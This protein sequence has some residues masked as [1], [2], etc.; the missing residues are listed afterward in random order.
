MYRTITRIEAL[1]SFFQK[2]SKIMSLTRKMIECI[3]RGLI[4]S[5]SSTVYCAKG[6]TL[7]ETIV[8]SA[9]LAG[10]A[11]GATYFF[12]QN[13]TIMLS[14]SQTMGCQAIAKQ[15]LESVMS[16][17]S[18]LYGYKVN[19]SDP[20][21][22][23]R[24]VWLQNNDIVL[25]QFPP[26]MYRDLF[27]KIGLS[28]NA[29]D[30]PE[31]NS[32]VRLIR[33][34]SPFLIETSTSVLLINFVNA[35]QYL[36]N[37]DPNEYFSA[38]GKEVTMPHLETLEGYKER[39]G[40]RD[41]KF[42]IKISPFNLATNEVMNSNSDIQ[43][44]KT[45]YN[46]S[47]YVISNYSCPT[48]AG[49]RLIVTRPRFHNPN[50]ITKILPNIQIVG[51]PDI[52]FELKVLVDYTLNE[53]EFSCEGMH[54][55]AHQIKH[56]TG[57]PTSGPV[58]RSGGSDFPVTLG[59]LESG[60]GKDLTIDPFVSCDT[61]T[62]GD[63]DDISLEL[64]FNNTDECNQAGTIILCQMNSY[65]KSE[66]NGS[67]GTCSP[68]E[69]TWQMCDH[70]QPTGSQ[71]WTFSANVS[72]KT[73]HFND[74]QTDRRYE[75][76]VGEFSTAGV[77]LREK[78]IAK[79]Y[80]DAT[81][82]TIGR[83]R[84]RFDNVGVP[85]DG[86]KG[87]NYSS[88][89]PTNWKVPPNST[90]KWI[91]CNDEPVHFQAEVKDQFEHNITGCPNNPRKGIQVERKDGKNTDTLSA[92]KKCIDPQKMK[93]DSNG[94]PYCW[95]PPDPGALG[96]AHHCDGVLGERGGDVK[97]GRHT[98]TF[99]PSDSCGQSSG[100]WDLVWDTDLPNTFA[101]QNFN[102][103][104]NI[105]WLKSADGL[106]YPIE[107][108]VPAKAG[109]GRFPKHYSVDCD[110]NY[111]LNKTRDGG[112]GP[113]L[114][115]KCELEPPRDI[116]HDNGCNP[117]DFGVKYYH[118]CGGGGVCKKAKWAVY[119]PQNESCKNVPCDPGDDLLCCQDATYCGSSYLKCLRKSTSPNPSCAY[120]KDGSQDIQSGCPHLGLYD[121][122]YNLECA[123]GYKGDCGGKKDG[124]DCKYSVITGYSP[125]NTCSPMPNPP[126]SCMCED[127]EVRKSSCSDDGSGGCREK[128]QP[129]NPLSDKCS[130]RSSVCP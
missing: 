13:K 32:G 10:M 79:F 4:R 34:V 54:L 3:R 90:S 7:V 124:Q 83:R 81:R 104:S 23:Y 121:C 27:E 84:I 38:Q 14:S 126:S 97:H 60:A 110:K 109:V 78:V 56:I 35:L 31:N 59:A 33:R 50:N 30:T 103:P 58:C 77:Y 47:A 113:L 72:S 129:Y 11:L 43:C 12:A 96:S 93:I 117:A 40:L 1:M 87:R 39:F 111:I 119:A 128:S 67:H 127:T 29:N 71:N 100:S 91:Q 120:P 45:Q 51:N 70:I 125:C 116:D 20:N 105:K 114:P 74:M 106:A 92:V 123:S 115:L 18:R 8:I 2:I 76:N 49:R 57:E 19:H 99:I 26:Q 69:G 53:Q 112:N 122:H 17:G 5:F 118:V 52:G 102:F 63:Y 37:S 65:C 6:I 94:D 86:S 75:L 42:Y 108:V 68:V 15:A 62:G 88:S 82:P 85:N 16:L 24:S 66:G 61:D 80:L 41:I 130:D 107:T 9:L 36:Y 101:A 22:D 48:R 95:S 46:G 25:R 28:Y 21:L 55:Y 44:K 64:I 73:L 98:V 89:R